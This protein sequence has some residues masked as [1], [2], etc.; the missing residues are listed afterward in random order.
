MCVVICRH[1]YTWDFPDFLG[2]PSSSKRERRFSLETLQC[3]RA[4]SNVQGRISWFAW[5]CGEKLRV[6]LELCVDL[7]D[8]GSVT[9]WPIQW[10]RLNVEG[11]SSIPGLGSHMW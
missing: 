4:S 7:G 2:L 10:L 1:S 3:K 8:P 9:L 11:A 5:S 6:A